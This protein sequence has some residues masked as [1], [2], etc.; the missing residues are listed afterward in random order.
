[1]VMFMPFALPAAKLPPVGW[2]Q[3][4]AGLVVLGKKLKQSHYRPGVAQRVP[5]S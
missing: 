3:L 2:V 4:T 1:V 5:E